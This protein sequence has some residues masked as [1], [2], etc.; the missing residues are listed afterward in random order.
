MATV[1]IVK[2]YNECGIFSGKVFQAW[3]SWARKLLRKTW[4]VMSSRRLAV[5]ASY[6]GCALCKERKIFLKLFFQI[7]LFPNPRAVMRPRK[8][9]QELG[10]GRP[11]PIILAH[12]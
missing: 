7:F 10:N 2:L 12:E 6:D 3:N 11:N 9:F 5:Y 1:H 4:H 8:G